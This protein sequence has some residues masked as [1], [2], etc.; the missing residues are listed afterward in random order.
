MYFKNLDIAFLNELNE[1]L[2]VRITHG[3]RQMIFFGFMFFH[4]FKTAE[5]LIPTLV[6]LRRT[7]NFIFISR[8]ILA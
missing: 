6:G 2:F 3:A 5:S 7:Q 4:E 1:L 8:Q